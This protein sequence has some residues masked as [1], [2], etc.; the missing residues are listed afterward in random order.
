M[1][2]VNETEPYCE[3]AGTGDALVLVHGRGGDLRYWDEQ[4]VE[5]A[6]D[7]DVLRYDLRG[8]GK[9]AMPVAGEPHRHEDDL[10]ALLLSLGL[11]RAHIAGYSLGSQIVFDAHTLYPGLFRSIV[12]KSQACCCKAF[13]TAHCRTWP[14]LP[15]SRCW[16]G[17]RK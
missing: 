7:F 8:Y 1:A 6:G 11:P 2:R 5:L 4:F 9:Y 12:A 17:R 15:T 13:P 14:R 10:H 16:R 3:R